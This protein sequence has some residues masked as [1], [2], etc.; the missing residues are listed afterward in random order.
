MQGRRERSLLPVG[1]STEDAAVGPLTPL[2]LPGE[3][4]FD[5]DPATNADA[6]S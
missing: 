4:G 2:G 1:E 6:H 5:V 3:A